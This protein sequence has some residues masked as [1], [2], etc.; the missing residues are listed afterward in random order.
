MGNNDVQKNGKAWYLK[1]GAR[2]FDLNTLPRCTAVAKSTGKQCKNPAMNG[3]MYC[4]V[5]NGWYKPGAPKGNQNRYKHGLYSQKAKE[6]RDEARR[7][8][9]EGLDFLKD[10]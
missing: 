1:N 8:L 3:S 5:H 6:E 7:I 2:G 9:R 10:L 4:C